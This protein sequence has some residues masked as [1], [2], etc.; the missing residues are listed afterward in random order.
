VALTSPRLG[1]RAAT[2]VDI[3][4]GGAGLEIDEL[5]IPAER[6]T[7]AFQ[8]PT[9]WDPLVLSAVI[10]WS[11]P[12]HQREPGASLPLGRH[13]PFARAGVH[14]DYPSPDVVFAMYEML[15]TLDYE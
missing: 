9:L 6:V 11:A 5:F 3:S 7:I 10:A 15:T 4:L 12:A 14:F 1:E 2:V 13:R 8:T